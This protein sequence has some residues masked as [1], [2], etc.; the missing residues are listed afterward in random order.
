MTYQS[1][2]RSIRLIFTAL[3]PLFLLQQFGKVL[4]EEQH[5]I[6][7]VLYFAVRIVTLYLFFFSIY[8]FLS[9]IKNVRKLESPVIFIIISSLFV[10]L[11]FAPPIVGYAMTHD[12]KMD[13][14][15]THLTANEAKE[16]AMNKN[17][18]P[19]RRFD[20]VR[21][22]YLDTGTRLPYLNGNS[23]EVLYTPDEATLKLQA[24]TVAADRKLKASL[25]NLKITALSLIGL[26]V[27][28]I[29]CF[30][31]LLKYRFPHQTHDAT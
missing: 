2:S 29:I 14:K 8:S 19:L 6:L 22:Y 24:E 12:L 17:V 26:L 25:A 20:L 9:K 31:V 5:L 16:E 13:F 28:S 18:F 27:T 11:S 1:Y 30:A 4:F 10:I 7:A 3:A 15:H 23:N 21:S